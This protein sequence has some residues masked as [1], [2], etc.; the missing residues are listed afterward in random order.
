MRNNF[1]WHFGGLYTTLESVKYVNNPAEMIKNP[2][3]WGAIS[4]ENWYRPQLEA[5]PHAISL[6]FLLGVAKTLN[7]TRNQWS[8]VPFVSLSLGVARP[9]DILLAVLNIKVSQF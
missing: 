1:S 8:D 3:Q 9:L 6:R 5:M 7:C 2:L 4:H